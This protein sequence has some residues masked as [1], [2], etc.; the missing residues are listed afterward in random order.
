MTFDID[1]YIAKALKCELLDKLAIR[2]ITQK[3]IQLLM[4]EENVR[5]I[6]APIS[7]VGDLHGQFYDLIELFKVGGLPPDTSYIFLGDFVDRGLRSVEL[8]T[9]LTLFKIKYPER[10]TMIRGNHETKKTSIEYGF[11]AECQKKYGGNTDVWEYFN[12]M[13]DYLPIAAVIDNSIFCVHG[14]LSP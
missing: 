11:Y 2:I 14:G 7:V 5:H 1:K 3:A 10:I 8:I 6:S 4:R 12:E 13:F 9:L